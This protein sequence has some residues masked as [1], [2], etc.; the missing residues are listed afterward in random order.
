MRCRIPLFTLTMYCNDYSYNDRRYE[1]AGI[2]LQRYYSRKPIVATLMV[3]VE[4]W[5][6]PINLKLVSRRMQLR[7]QFWPA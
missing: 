6:H 2:Q 4:V 1:R 5:R 7:V 3:A